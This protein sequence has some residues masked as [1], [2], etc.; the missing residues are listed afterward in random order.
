[1]PEHRDLVGL[2]H[3]AVRMCAV[4]IVS[5]RA[6]KTCRAEK[7]EKLLNRCFEPRSPLATSRLCTLGSLGDPLAPYHQCGPNVRE[8]ESEGAWA[9]S[10][11]K[12]V[13]IWRGF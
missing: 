10:L 9:K 13:I 11:L 5:F 2:L 4:E 12:N 8:F 3:R 6:E 7:A 1:M